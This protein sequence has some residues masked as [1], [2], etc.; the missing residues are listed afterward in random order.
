MW[1][2][3]T[4]YKV[5]DKNKLSVPRA[6]TLHIFETHPPSPLNLKWAGG[7]SG[8]PVSSLQLIMS[9]R[10]FHP[11]FLLLSFTFFLRIHQHRSQHARVKKP[12]ETKMR[13]TRSVFRN[14]CSQN[15]CL[16]STCAFQKDANF[17]FIHFSCFF[18]V[19]NSSVALLNDPLSEDEEESKK[20][21]ICLEWHS[22][23]LLLLPKVRKKTLTTR[24]TPAKK[25][26]IS[27][28]CLFFLTPPN[29]SSIFFPWPLAPNK[30]G[31]SD[32]GPESFTGH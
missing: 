5:H 22:I 7:T 6:S 10:R 1:T 16:G 21:L 17:Y 19:L 3:I 23:L 20:I 8:A 29:N 13:E 15:Y 12:F 28:P 18:A 24:S 25:W 14:S 30:F 9:A 4:H 32:M 2:L 31:K 11:C 27:P 26:V